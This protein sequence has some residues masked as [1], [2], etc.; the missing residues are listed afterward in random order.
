MNIYV[1]YL[2]SFFL[3]II[4]GMTKTKIENSISSKKVKNIEKKLK[5]VLEILHNI[6]DET[7][8]F[9]LGCLNIE[10]IPW[11]SI[12]DSSLSGWFEKDCRFSYYEDFKK[13]LPQELLD[14]IESHWEFE[15]KFNLKL[16]NGERVGLL[17]L[18]LN[19]ETNKI[20]P[21]FEFYITN[22]KNFIGTNKC[23]EKFPRSDREAWNS[24]KISSTRGYEYISESLFSNDLA[25]AT[26]IITKDRKILL[27]KRT[28]KVHVLPKY[29]H[30]SIAEG[31][32]PQK[33]MFDNSPNPF[34]TIVRGAKE[35][36]NLSIN[37]KDIRMLA[38]GLYLPYSQPFI[39]CQVESN[40]TLKELLDEAGNYINSWEGKLLPIEF[41]IEVLAP[42]LLDSYK[43]YQNINVAPL[44]KYCITLCLAREY[45]LEKVKMRLKELKKLL[46]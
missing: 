36:L 35:E 24:E 8:H 11:L 5:N 10:V 41:D 16:K 38:T 19:K 37:Q 32:L 34:L 45:G 3:G 25:T 42:F 12:N 1:G 14:K 30:T 9:Q 6:E 27:S 15:K 20:I 21:E 17:N 4:G 22:Y 13:E 43:S 40:K 39:V 29:I 44:A 26:T 23:Y 28:D 33:D 46:Q 18:I 2:I 31:M 7:D